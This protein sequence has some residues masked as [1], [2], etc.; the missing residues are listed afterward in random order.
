[1]SKLKSNKK[2]PLEAPTESDEKTRK[3]GPY[4][5]P[6]TGDAFNIYTSDRKFK[7][8]NVSQSEHVKLYDA[9]I[10]RRLKELEDKDLVGDN[11]MFESLA[12]RL[13]I[14]SEHECKKM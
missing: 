6:G 8:S 7:L 14:S 9:A 3:F 12:H 10:D 4:S 11:I 13:L 1:M 2:R 5:T